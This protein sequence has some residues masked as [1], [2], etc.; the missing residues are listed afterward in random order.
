MDNKI[1][2]E[3]IKKIRT[4]KI[5]AEDSVLSLPRFSERRAHLEGVEKTLNDVET[6]LTKL[7]KADEVI[8]LKGKKLWQ[9]SEP[10][11]GNLL[12]KTAKELK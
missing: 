5:N 4:Q 6:E 8:T 9:K 2:E 1:L 10:S 3:Y 7:L 11:I 12:V